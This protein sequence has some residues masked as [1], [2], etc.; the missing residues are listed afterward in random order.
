MRQLKYIGDSGAAQWYYESPMFF[1]QAS[2]GLALVYNSIAGGDS[3]SIL[4]RAGMQNVTGRKRHE[5]G[6]V[7]DQPCAAVV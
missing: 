2:S 4:G 7:G 5:F 6:H 3:R 1:P